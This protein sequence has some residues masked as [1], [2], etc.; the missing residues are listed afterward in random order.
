M[1]AGL[2]VAYAADTGASSEAVA[3]LIGGV[4]SGYTYRLST[5]AKSLAKNFVAFLNTEVLPS[6]DALPAELNLMSTKDKEKV[7]DGLRKQSPAT[8]WLAH[9][10]ESSTT[11]QV[12]SALSALVKKL[13]P[14]LGSVVVKT[15][16][17]LTTELKTQVR[18]HFKDDF[19][20]FI[21]DT[22]LLGGILV[23]KNGQLIDK[24][25]LGKIKAIASLTK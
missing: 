14:Q 1:I 20:V 17:D 22:S 6:F 15:P 3:E 23:Y 8:K 24:S 11:H 21:T 2:L 13:A 4:T 16:T 5:P 9:L 10:L 7:L 12:Q 25:W 18:K 19:V